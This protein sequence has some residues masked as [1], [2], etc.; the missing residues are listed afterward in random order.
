[1]DTVYSTKKYFQSLG[2]DYYRSPSVSRQMVSEVVISD[3]HFEFIYQRLGE[4]F[5]ESFSA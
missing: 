1:M 2:S 4:G 5:E 3:T